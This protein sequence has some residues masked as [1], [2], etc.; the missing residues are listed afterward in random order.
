VLIE[1]PFSLPFIDALCIILLSPF[2]TN[3]NKRGDKGKPCLIPY[4]A[5]KKEV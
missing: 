3:R 1:I 4:L 5:L 2:A